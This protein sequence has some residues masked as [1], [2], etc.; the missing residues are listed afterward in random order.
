MFKVTLAALAWPATTSATRSPSHGATPFDTLGAVL[1]WFKLTGGRKHSLG[2]HR[3][4]RF[5]RRFSSLTML[6]F[7]RFVK[8]N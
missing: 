2:D 1:L 5:L 3:L 6:G 7:R 4:Q 8:V